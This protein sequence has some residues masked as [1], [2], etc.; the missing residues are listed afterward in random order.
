MKEQAPRPSPFEHDRSPDEEQYDFRKLRE[1]M[2]EI[3]KYEKL[4]RDNAS[5]LP[6]ALDHA[7]VP[8]GVDSLNLYFGN[9]EVA[10]IEQKVNVCNALFNQ[11]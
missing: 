2:Q 4:D 6:N 9:Q 7:L 1:I 10:R 5:G 8:H 3:T 11:H